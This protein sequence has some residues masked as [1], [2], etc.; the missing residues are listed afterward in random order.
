MIPSPLSY[1]PVETPAYITGTA[2]VLALCV[3]P[4]LFV[5]I[6]LLMLVMRT[7]RAPY[8]AFLCAFG[9]LGTLSLGV[10]SANS[11]LSVLSFLIAIPV[12]PVLMVHQLVVL[13]SRN[14]LSIFHRIAH[15]ACLVSLTIITTLVVWSMIDGH[16]VSM[17]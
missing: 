12:C 6:S 3:F 9:A 5:I 13:H 4:A 16:K 14:S 17:D 7:P 8:F 10:A 1:A 15:W 11:P 2:V